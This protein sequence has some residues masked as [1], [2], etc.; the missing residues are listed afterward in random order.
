MQFDDGMG[1]RPRDFHSD[2]NCR[3]SCSER[4]KEW[5]LFVAGD[6]AAVAIISHRRNDGAE[7]WVRPIH[8]TCEN[9]NV[10]FRKGDPHQPHAAIYYACLRS[11]ADPHDT[12]PM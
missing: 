3:S 6:I 10:R 9:S 1:E 11:W 5:P 12:R 4:H 8:R 7:S 2:F